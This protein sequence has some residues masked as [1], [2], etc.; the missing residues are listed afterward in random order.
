VLAI[1]PVYI[2]ATNFVKPQ[3]QCQKITAQECL[4]KV[5]LHS[6]TEVLARPPISLD[7][8]SNG[9]TAFPARAGSAA[10]VRPE[11]PPPI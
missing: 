5:K 4:T 10:A 8:Y 1:P 9:D 3:L 6:N 11:S 7:D 2:F